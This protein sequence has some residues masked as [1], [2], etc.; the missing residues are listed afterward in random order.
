VTEQGKEENREDLAGVP[1]IAL[2]NG[3]TYRRAYDSSC[4]AYSG[5]RS[6]ATGVCSCSAPSC[7]RGSRWG[8]S[9]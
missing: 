8:R 4:A 9:H 7:R 2:A 3:W 1:E 5:S 6:S